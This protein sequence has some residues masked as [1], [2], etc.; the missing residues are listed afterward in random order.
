[1]NGKKILV[2]DDEASVRK[3]VRS[4]LEKEGFQVIE[5]ADG[6][7]AIELARSE[8]PTLMVLDLMLPGVDGLEVCRSICGETD[9]SGAP[10]PAVLMLTARADEA[11]KL[12]GLGMGADDY[13]TKPFS[14][15]ELV[16]RVKAILRR[17][18]AKAPGA[19]AEAATAISEPSPGAAP[20][21][22]GIL[23][24]GSIEVDPARHEASIDGRK[25]D[26]T[27]REFEILEVLVTDPGIV[28]SREKLL[29]RVWGINY[30]GDPRVVD[31]HIAKLRK[32]L[33]PDAS[34]PRYLITVRGVGYKLR[35]GEA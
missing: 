13:L 20:S 4:Y 1:M 17:S 18:A 35:P 3:L 21:G 34:R 19:A 7:R 25:L 24:A 16:A 30:Y 27:A 32:K 8:R 14:P 26:L 23:K 12:V 22:A 11:D 5:A 29:E 31:V 9:A 15:R 6:N 10:S 2:V 28:F 33:E